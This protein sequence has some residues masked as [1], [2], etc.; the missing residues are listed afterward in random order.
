MPTFRKNGLQNLEIHSFLG[1]VLR[2]PVYVSEEVKK[3]DFSVSISSIKFSVILDM[4][5][6]H[7]YPDECFLNRKV[8]KTFIVNQDF[9]IL[10]ANWL[11]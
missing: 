5:K 8:N 2:F 3:T 10:K 9:N 7:K 4:N 6:S 1:L 11:P